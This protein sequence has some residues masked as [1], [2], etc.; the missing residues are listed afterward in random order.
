MTVGEAGRRVTRGV[1]ASAVGTAAAYLA[2]YVLLDWISFIQPFDQLNITAWNP[3]PGVSLVL[4]LVRGMRWAPL[5]F[6]GPFAAD[7]IVRHLSAPVLPTLVTDLAEAVIYTGVAWLIRRLVRPSLDFRAFREVVGLIAATALGALFMAVVYV[8]SFTLAGRVPAHNMGYLTFEYWLG[9]TVGILV[10]VPFLLI[11][12]RLISQGIA[13]AGMVSW[14]TVGQCAALGLSLSVLFIPVWSDGA[15]AFYAMFAP[16]V[17]VA[18]KRGLP[19]VAVFL[20]AAQFALVGGE[21]VLGFHG[22]IIAKLQFLMLTLTVTGLLLGV[23]IS[24]REAALKAVAQGRSRLQTAIDMAPDALLVTDEVGRINVANGAFERLS[25]VPRELAV[26]RP[27]SEFIVSSVPPA[28]PQ[29]M[30]RHADGSWLAVEVLVAPLQM[31]D[32]QG[33]VVTARDISARKRSEEERNLRRNTLEQAGRVNFSEKLAASLAH[34]LNQP[35]SA[36]IGYT[37][38]CQKL[39]DGMPWAPE[40]L[41]LLM[42]KAVT[43]AERA[44]AIVSRLSEFFRSGRIEPSTLSMRDFLAD[45]TGLLHEDAARIGARIGYD[46]AGEL[47]VEADRLQVEL[48]LVNLVRNSIE[49][50]ADSPRADRWIEVTAR[51]DKDQFVVVTVC[52]NGQGIA[53]EI[54]TNLFDAFVTARPNGTGLGLAIS[55]S[56]VASHGGRLW[57]DPSSPQGACFHFTLPAARGPAAGVPTETAHAD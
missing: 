29:S 23:V 12:R 22:L 55:Q 13:L 45:V 37:A 54:A 40:R 42:G 11:H 53:E 49:V 24:E 51:P 41:H 32:H 8:G 9:D 35:L 33:S 25:G 19:G 1:A 16:L 7:V 56:I 6:V 57:H 27:V 15:H 2:A 10:I 4:L 26:G 48:V 14:Q 39:V 46:V 43:Q 50:L 47:W 28:L 18:A 31:G 34:E 44:G 20:L 21:L 36:L 5:V 30:F 38:I 17:W 3:P 52:D